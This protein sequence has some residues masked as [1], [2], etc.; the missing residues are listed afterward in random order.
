MMNGILYLVGTPIGNLEDISLRALRIL[1]EV[2]V[3]AAED[4]RVTRVLLSRYEIKKRLISYREH[5]KL[6]SNKYIVD[7]LKEGKSIA[8]VCDRGMPGISDAGVLPYLI[9]E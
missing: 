8:L 9:S 6:K 3:I 4:T 1:K 5:N 7:S 2:D